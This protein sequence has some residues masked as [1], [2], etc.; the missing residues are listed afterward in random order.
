MNRERFLTEAANTGI[1]RD[2]AT[3]LYERLYAQPER[4]SELSRDGTPFDSQ[5]GLSRTVQVL[6]GIGVLLVIGAHAWW[7]TQGYEA[8]HLTNTLK[9][10]MMFFNLQLGLTAAMV[11]VLLIRWLATA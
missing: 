3:A 1:D 8:N 2:A 10:L 4:R 11:V 5:T 6:V 9:S 7:S